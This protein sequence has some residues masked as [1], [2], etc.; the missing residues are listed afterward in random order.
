MGYKVVLLKM[1]WVVLM[2]GLQVVRITTATEKAGETQ[3]HQ[4]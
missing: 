4:R 3:G 1:S 2:V